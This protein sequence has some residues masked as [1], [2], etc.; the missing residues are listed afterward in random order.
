[1]GRVCSRWE[2]V[3]LDRRCWRRRAPA[4][5]IALP[6][7]RRELRRRARWSVVT[8]TSID[9]RT[10]RRRRSRPPVTAGVVLLRAAG[11]TSA[12]AVPLQPARL[13]AA[14]SGRRRAA[15]PRLHLFADAARPTPQTPGLI[16]LHHLA[17]IH[18][19]VPELSTDP[20]PIQAAQSKRAC[21]SV[22]AFATWLVVPRARPPNHG[23]RGGRARGQAA[24]E[25]QGE[26]A[27]AEAAQAGVPVRECKTAGA[28]RR[29][30]RLPIVVPLCL[31]ARDRSP[32]THTSTTRTQ[33]TPQARGGRAAP[34]A[35]AA[36]ATGGGAGQFSHQKTRSPPPLPR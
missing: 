26:E 20:S 34:R 4:A 9:Q 17:L 5:P 16:R 7:C 11:G 15:P 35:P 23:R 33:H 18:A 12:A 3:E 36:A 27:A 6:V 14:E 30:S 13:P 1:M 8:G 32:D 22:S 31:R 29:S 19:R 28:T 21:A 25:A 24:R 10:T 2:S